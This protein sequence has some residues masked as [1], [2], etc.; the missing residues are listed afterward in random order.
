MLLGFLA[1]CAA[2]AAP[3]PGPP[4][5]SP[6]APAAPKRRFVVEASPLAQDIDDDT[7]PAPCDLDRSYRGKIGQT[8]VTLLLKADPA[9]RAGELRGSDHYDQAGAAIAISGSRDKERFV[10]N[11]KQGG[12][13]EGAC[14]AKGALVGKF[15]LKGKSTPFS[16]NPRPASWPALYR[17][18]RKATAEPDHPL[19]KKVAK[20]DVAVE[21][22]EGDDGPRV[23]CLPTSAA[24]RK[25]LLKESDALLCSASDQGYRVFGLGDDAVEARVN[26]ALTSAAFDIA[27]DENRSCRHVRQFHEEISLVWAQRDLV[28]VTSFRSE[29]H[30]G[31]H[32]LNHGGGTTV[33]DLRDGASVA[34][35]QLVD[36]ARL[37]PLAGACLPY[38]APASGDAKGFEIEVDPP[39]ATCG[40]EPTMARFLWGCSS[41]DIKTPV[42]T[43]LPSGLVIGA[44]GNPHAM[45]A[46]D[47]HG[48]VLPWGVLLRDGLLK[49]DSPLARLWK[50]VKPAGPSAPACSS[51]Y[52][53]NK[54]ISWRPEGG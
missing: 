3:E 36:P 42:W 14:D 13:F 6:I 46:N 26:R 28:V 49:A 43:L 40:N 51:A 45:A 34:L 25:S 17:V 5:A 15:T 53:G 23:V 48:P 27:R 32:P 38:Y 31:A 20:R 16:L 50:G 30:G 52:E 10:L 4:R 2:P 9:A 33:V 47:G 41:D 8:P 24:A 22:S 21:T 44:W 37:L 35:E 39:P 12:T 1:G 11:E 29:D 7:G 19:C 54:L 18:S